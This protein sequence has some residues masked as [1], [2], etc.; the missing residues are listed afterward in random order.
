MTNAI[1]IRLLLSRFSSSVC[2]LALLR[3]LSPVAA[4]S[5]PVV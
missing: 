3:P 1:G 5:Q 2:L 4:V